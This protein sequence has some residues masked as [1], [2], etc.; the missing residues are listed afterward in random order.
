MSS[1]LFNGTPQESR[2][3]KRARDRICR[4]FEEAKDERNTQAMPD[5]YG[6]GR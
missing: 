4:S 5:K 6:V 3:Q 2:H 1:T